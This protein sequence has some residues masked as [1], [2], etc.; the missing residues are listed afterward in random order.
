[1]KSTDIKSIK[2]SRKY[3][4]AL[5]NL[6]VENN[7][8]DKIYDDLI[9]VVETI[10]TNI[11]LKNF[12]FS[13]IIK[14]EDKKDVLQKLFSIHI[15]KTTL[16]FL[17]LLIDEN[18]L[19]FIEGILNQFSE[20]YNNSKNIVK[21]LIISAIDLNENQKQRLV[22]KLEKKLEKKVLPE[23]QIKPEIV[24]GL[25]IEI[26]DKTIDCSIKTKFNNMKKELTKGNKYG[27]N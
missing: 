4:N 1:M 6:A 14:N 7:N 18:R 12:L 21:P 24:G 10:N 22:E 17:Y 15:N 2:I 27:N 25:I 5:F 11:E 3:S 13:P 8:N 20:L 9:F 19:N 26:G 16:D 23:Y